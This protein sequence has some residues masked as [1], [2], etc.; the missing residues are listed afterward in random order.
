MEYEST[1]KVGY[2]LH[3]FFSG[4]SHLDTVCCICSANGC[5][6]KKIKWIDWKNIN[7]QQNSLQQKKNKGYTLVGNFLL[8][9]NH[10]S[11]S[12][13]ASNFFGLPLDF[14]ETLCTAHP[15]QIAYPTMWKWT[16]SFQW[17][18][19]D[20]SR[21]NELLHRSNRRTTGYV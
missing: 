20:E 9:A 4:P 1:F 11:H 12:I 19:C 14:W 21:G 17:N 7:I 3:Q 8:S 13:L 16:S 15:Y 10:D 5:F 2:M 18:S 6:E